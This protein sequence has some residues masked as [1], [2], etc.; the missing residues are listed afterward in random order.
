MRHTR[1]ASVAIALRYITQDDLWTDNTSAA[2][3]L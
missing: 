2:L 3:G 1:H